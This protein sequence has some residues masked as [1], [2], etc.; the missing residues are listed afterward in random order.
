M[1]LNALLSPK[2]ETNSAWPP[3]FVKLEF[4]EDS[5]YAN[6]LSL[7]GSTSLPDAS[8]NLIVK[9]VLT[10]LPL[11]LF[12][13]IKAVIIGS[14]ENTALVYRFDLVRIVAHKQ[15]LLL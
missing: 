12:V 3:L 5:A 8:K 6:G 10:S 4:K 1:Y 13:P 14:F 9:R 11:T 15:I 7:S 2:S